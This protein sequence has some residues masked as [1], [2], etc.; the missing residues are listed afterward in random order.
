MSL[1]VSSQFGALGKRRHSVRY[2]Q[3]GWQYYN[4]L[5]VCAH[6]RRFQSRSLLLSMILQPHTKAD[7]VGS[8]ITQNIFMWLQEPKWKYVILKLSSHPMSVTITMAKYQ[9]IWRELCHRPLP[10]S[11]CTSKIPRNEQDQVSS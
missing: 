4:V 5:C 1:Y 7:Y 10:P 2:V 8:P 6:I 11:T 9:Y 3:R